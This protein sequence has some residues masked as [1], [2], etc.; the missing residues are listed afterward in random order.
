MKYGL[1]LADSNETRRYFAEH[2][3]YLDAAKKGQM[4]IPHVVRKMTK[5]WLGQLVSWKRQLSRTSLSLG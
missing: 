4:A 1:G 5:T 2:C 3:I